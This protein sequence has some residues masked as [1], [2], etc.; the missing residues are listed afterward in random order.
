MKGI[1]VK[2]GLV[3]GIFTSVVTLVLCWLMPDVAAGYTVYAITFGVAFGLA[4]FY[5]ITIKKELPDG[6]TIAYHQAFINTIIL[7]CVGLLI[8][9]TSFAV[10]KGLVFPE[11]PIISKEKT[12][13]VYDKFIEQYKKKIETDGSKAADMLVELNAEKAQVEKQDF[14]PIIKEN[15]GST[16]LRIL[17]WTA[18]LGSLISII[19]SFLGTRSKPITTI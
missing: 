3:I 5:N 8:S 2:Y 7:C 10:L 1:A 9:F 15:I 17:L 19:T 6:A 11:I 16:F 14:N 4:L 13:A 18:V 12:I